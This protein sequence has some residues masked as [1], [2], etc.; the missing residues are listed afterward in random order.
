MI[1]N[2]NN[3]PARGYAGADHEWTWGSVQRVDLLW[4]GVDPQE[5]HARL[6]R[7]RDEQAATQDLRAVR[8]LPVIDEVLQRVPSPSA[9][10]SR[11][12]DLLRDWRSKGSSRLDRELDGGIDHPGAAILDEAW[13]GLADAVLTPVLGPLVAD[14]AALVP[15]DQPMNAGGSSFSDGWW[16]YVD[17]DLRTLLG[18]PVK[19][20]YRTRFCGGGVIAACAQSLWAALDAA[21][22]RL[23][24][25]QGLD[26]AAWRADANAERIR[27]ARDSPGDD[28]RSQPADVPAADDLPSHR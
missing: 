18:K 20:A 23:E 26:P 22:A 10:A 27:F 6:G 2:W 24:V 13:N 11:A 15:R 7:R 21:A 19:G 14:L 17:K 4:A 12:L 9:R 28:A 3:K 1:L 8:V 16:S 5:A 25:R